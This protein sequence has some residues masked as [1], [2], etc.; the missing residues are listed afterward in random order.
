MCVLFFFLPLVGLDESRSRSVT[1]SH[2]S[3][4]RG[5]VASNDAHVQMPPPFEPQCIFLDHEAQHMVAQLGLA[6]CWSRGTKWWAWSLT[7]HLLRFKNTIPSQEPDSRAPKR[8]FTLQDDAKCFFFY[9]YTGLLVIYSPSISSDNIHPKCWYRSP[10][11][12]DAWFGCVNK[13]SEHLTA[14]LWF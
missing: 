2:W 10:A 4:V 8:F 6:L 9:F 12:P 11:V 5:P 14:L 1:S 3:A 7:L 13:G